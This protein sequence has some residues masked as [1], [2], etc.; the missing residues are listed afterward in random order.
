MAQLPRHTP[1]LQRA[2]L[3]LRS[4][5][6]HDWRNETTDSHQLCGKPFTRR[7]GQWVGI[8][9]VG[10]MCNDNSIIVENVISES[11]GDI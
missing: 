3:D 8:F 9:V 2:E 4:I 6:A 1:V 5:K 11:R 10:D 7:G